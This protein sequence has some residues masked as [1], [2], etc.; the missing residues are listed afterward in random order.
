MDFRRLVIRFRQFGGIR[1]VRK[2]NGMGLFWPIVKAFFSCLLRG[3]SFKQIYPVILQ[4]VEPFLE[5][6]YDPV[7]SRF[8]FQDSNRLEHKR[9]KIIWFCWLQGMEQAPVLVHVCYE[10]LKQNLPDRVIKV[11]DAKN[12]KE[13]I[14][15]PDYVIHRWEKKRHRLRLT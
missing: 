5:Q 7:A 12:W 4:K 8:K 11:I 15:L 6:R 10:S 2:Y 1:L 14:E 3:Q 13:Y 9:S